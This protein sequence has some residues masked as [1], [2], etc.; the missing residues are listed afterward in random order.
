[1]ARRQGPE[2]KYYP[3]VWRFLRR[4]ISPLPTPREGNT[5]ASRNGLSNRFSHMDQPQSLRHRYEPESKATRD[6]RH[7]HR[8]R[9]ERTTE[10]SRLPAR[11]WKTDVLPSRAQRS[12]DDSPG[13]STGVEKGADASEAGAY[14]AE[15]RVGQVLPAGFST[16]PDI[17][18]VKRKGILG[19][20]GR[21]RWL[22]HN[23]GDY[24]RFQ[25][26]C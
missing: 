16:V 2:E 8:Y 24:R 5:F 19:Q 9:P 3:Q 15:L 11:R 23:L 17:F 18:R 22:L 26:V 12:G 6:E 13:S 20:F 4:C 10:A 7:A 1:M 14:E 21:F 25:K